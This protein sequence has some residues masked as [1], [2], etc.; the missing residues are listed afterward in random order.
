M[1][2]GKICNFL[3]HRFADLKSTN[4]ITIKEKLLGKIR[5]EPILSPYSNIYLKPYIRRDYSTSPN[6]LKLMA[7]LLVK[8]NQNKDSWTLPPRYPLDYTYIQPEHIP[9]I[10]SLCNQFFW[11]GIDCMSVN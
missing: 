6:W 11:P 8:V 1:F 3:K 4:G 10:N 2:I 7:E 5:E 9:A